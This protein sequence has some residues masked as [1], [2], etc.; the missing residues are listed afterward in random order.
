M[1]N[2]TGQKWPAQTLLHRARILFPESARLIGRAVIHSIN[3]RQPIYGRR[4]ALLERLKVTADSWF[5]LDQLRSH[6][7]LG[8][9]FE[10]GGRAD[11][12]S[13]VHPST[14]DQSRTWE[15]LCNH[16]LQMASLASP[17]AQQALLAAQELLPRERVSLD[18]PRD[19]SNAVVGRQLRIG[20]ITPDVSYHPVCRFLLMQ[21]NRFSQAGCTYHFVRLAGTSGLGI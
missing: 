3:E 4:L 14:L 8:F 11:L 5:Q 20:L 17:L 19:Q 1:L 6:Q 15:S 18:V 7:N 21:L 2:A 16:A 9:A 10:T 12:L 13:A